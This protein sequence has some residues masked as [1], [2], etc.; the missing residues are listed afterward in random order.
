MSVSLLL[1]VVVG[2]LVGFGVLWLFVV[3]C[4]RLDDRWNQ[5]AVSSLRARVELNAIHRRTVRQLFDIAN[6]RDHRTLPVRVRGRFLDRGQ[7]E[8]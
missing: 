8:P 1:Q 5:S 2:A 6:G 7:D 3:V 4:T